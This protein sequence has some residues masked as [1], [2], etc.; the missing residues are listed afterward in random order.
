[1]EESKLSQISISP[2]K[3]DEVAVTPPPSAFALAAA[4]SEGAATPD[5]PST[6]KSTLAQ[7]NS[8]RRAAG[9]ESPASNSAK[10]AADHQANSKTSS[11]GGA[12]STLQRRNSSNSSSNAASNNRKALQLLEAKVQRWISLATSHKHA[13]DRQKETSD[14]KQ[15]SLLAMDA[16][17]AYLVA[18]DYDDK[19]AGIKGRVPSDKNWTTLVPFARHVINLHEK[20]ESTPLIGV[21]Y[22]TRAIVYLRMAGFHQSSARALQHSVQSSSAENN[23]GGESQSPET[24]V[25][26]MSGSS[27]AEVLEILAKLSRNIDLAAYEF[28]RGARLMS[29]DTIM[30]Q[31]PQTWKRRATSASEIAR[32]GLVP[33]GGSAQGPGLRPLEDA[34]MLP[35]QMNSSIREVAAFAASMLC[36]WAEKNG[37][38]LETVLS[39]GVT[40]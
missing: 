28:Q 6:K 12:K 20:S 35:I 7:Y 27:S 31:F 3:I 18:F 14:Y 25:S 39:R 24:S 32:G 33:L 10:T 4:A 5:T 11:T 29:I 36:E 2:T 37:L 30:E 23:A 15:A 38:K 9:E 34:F 1:K 26:G 19:C 16:L 21:T 17:L 22:L 13:A 8:K 40:E